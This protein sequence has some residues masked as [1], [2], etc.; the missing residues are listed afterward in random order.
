MTPP[1]R[2]QMLAR[3]GLIGAIVTVIVGAFAWT[4]GW[5]SPSR[6]SPGRIVDALEARNGEHPGVRRAHEKGLC[7]SGYF[8]SNGAGVALSE[9]GVFRAGRTPVFGRFS[10]GV[11]NPNSPDG[12]PGFHA[13]ALSFQQPDGQVWRTAMDDTPIFPVATPKAFID[14]QLAGVAD[15]A[16]G[17]PDPARMKAYLAAH[18]E[19]VAFMQWMKQAPFGASFAATTY[20]SI[21]AFRFTNGDGHVS[22]V[23]WSLK[24]QAPFVEIDKSKLA[25]LNKTQPH[26]LFDDLIHRLA[27]QPQ[28]WQLL[29]TLAKP[30]DPTNDA[31]RPWPQDREQ[32]DVGTLVLDRAELEDNGPCRDVTFDPLI[33]PQGIGASDDPL[34][35]ARSSA[36]ARSFSRRATETPPPSALSSDPAAK[37]LQGAHP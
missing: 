6:V 32:V 35:A 7:V 18:P 1:R 26:F 36:Y 34:L 33:L 10:L 20:Y 28:R 2:P 23:R 9:A 16:T 12:V 4:A 5:L 31:T 17:K 29:V 3:A 8:Q 27:A 22:A 15:K 19:T 30:Q 37:D 13:I 11:G 14:F 25:E 24:P 21:N